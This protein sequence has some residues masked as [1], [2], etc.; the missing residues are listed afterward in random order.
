MLR[1]LTSFHIASM[2]LLFSEKLGRKITLSIYDIFS[3][4]CSCSHSSAF[5]L[6]HKVK[7]RLE[8]FYS[9]SWKNE[10]CEILKLFHTATDFCLKLKKDIFFVKVWNQALFFANFIMFIAVTISFWFSYKVWTFC[11]D[12]EYKVKGTR[13]FQFRA[14]MHC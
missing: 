7:S 13:E 6:V 2:L 4:F 10:V 11:Q 12:L 9:Y 1:F 14:F 3:I 5:E 8:F